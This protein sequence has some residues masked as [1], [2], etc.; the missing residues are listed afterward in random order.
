VSASPFV[1]HEWVVPCFGLAAI[2]AICGI[3]LDPNTKHARIKTFSNDPN[4]G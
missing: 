2:F 4:G 1:R 3:I